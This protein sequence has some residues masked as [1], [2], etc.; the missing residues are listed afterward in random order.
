M[1]KIMAQ[2]L[3][4]SALM[5]FQNHLYAQRNPRATA[6]YDKA[7]KYVMVEYGRPSLKGREM[8]AQLQPGKLWR[9]GA[10][11]STTF[12]SNT[13]LS[14]AK[15]SIP[16]GSYSLWLRKI[17]DETFQLVFNKTTGQWGTEHDVT[18]DFASVPLTREQNTQNVEQFTI[19]LK[20]AAK[21]GE[22]ELT[23][24]KLILKAPFTLK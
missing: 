22:L 21:G 7:G 4:V 10:D 20:E 14:I 19:N 9:M 11:K 17:D 1:K 18:Q 6:K 8:L 12:T 23:W 24:G 2:S 15:V 16:Q 13:N 3:V 5:I